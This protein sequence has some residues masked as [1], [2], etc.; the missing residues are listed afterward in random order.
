MIGIFVNENGCIHY[1]RLMAGGYKKA[2]TRFRDML[3]K[4]VGER[5]A[6]IQ[7]RRHKNP[8]VIGYVTIVSKQFVKAEDFPLYFNDHCVPPGSSYDAHGR[9]K[10]LYWLKDAETCE[11]YDLPKDAIRHGRSWCEWV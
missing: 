4:L 8:Q 10:W 9:G 1:A 6:I 11:P 7:T 5:V 2:E 3:G